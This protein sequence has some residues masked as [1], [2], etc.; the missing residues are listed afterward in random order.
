MQRYANRTFENP[1]AVIEAFDYG[2]LVDAFTKIEQLR[3]THYLLGYIRYEA[4]HAL[5][6]HGFHADLPLLYFE[7][8]TGFTPYVPMPRPDIPV[9]VIPTIDFSD[10]NHALSRI[11]EEIADGNT[12]QVNYTYD[13]HIQ[14]P[15]APLELY[16]MLRPHQTTP[17]TAFIENQYESILSFSPELFFELDGPTIRAKPMKGT[18]KRGKDSAED[19][20]NRQFLQGDEKNR[21]ENV[22][23][24]DLLRND[25]GKV[26]IPGSV[27]VKNLFEVETHKTVHQ[28]TSEIVATLKEQT[29][30]W[31]IFL[32]LFPCGSVTG[33][34]KRSTM[35]IIDALERGPRGVYCGAIGFLEPGHATFSVPIRI[36][37]RTRDETAYRYRVGSGIVWDSDIREE[38]L[39]T[40]TKT[41][42]L[43]GDF[44][45]LETIRIQD[46]ALLYGPEH[47]AR[48]EQSAK[49]LGV[50]YQQPSLSNPPQ[51]D[52]ILRLLL[53]RDGT[54][55]TETHPYDAVKST[56]IQIAATRITSFDPMLQHKTT[57]RPWYT[58]TLEKIRQGLVFDELFMN[59]HGQLTE[60]ARSN[61][62]VQLKGI[63][64]TPPLSCGLLNGILRQ[65][66]LDDGTCIE[67][68]LFLDDLQH[69]ERIFCG[70]SVRGLVEVHIAST[71]PDNRCE[72][73]R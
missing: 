27:T 9:T 22:M 53:A 18:A 34:P 47:F 23:I 55:T 35:Q 30:L 15:L 44:Q 71:N 28:M 61:L 68:T 36:L 3:A 57:Y 54:L 69:A 73:K 59:E 24:V 5:L 43:H 11:K 67:R 52:A 33:A 70:N 29:T 56:R 65:K 25:L 48:M 40:Q 60:G 46:G 10:Y 39:E 4:K 42:F 7:A 63:L 51:S 50:A 2:G 62:F 72:T 14:T 37:Q 49:A 31:E 13:C 16:E 26:A 38:W 41:A 1:V 66:M 20:N 45:I 21:S 6:D 32:A 17:Y 8:Y 19:E 64:Y 58:A 12:Y